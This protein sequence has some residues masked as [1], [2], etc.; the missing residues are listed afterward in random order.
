MTD[1][2]KNEFLTKVMQHMD[3]CLNAEEIMELESEM[4]E[5]E[6]KRVLFSE[7][8]LQSASLQDHMANASTTETRA[9][10]PFIFSPWLRTAA[11]LIVGV[12]IGV[13]SMTVANAFSKNQALLPSLGKLFESFEEG[14]EPEA[15]GI[16][17]QTL[18]WGGDSSK[19]TLTDQ[20]ITP[21]DG[22][23]MLRFLKADYPGKPIPGGYL[24]EIYRWVDLNEFNFK[25]DSEELDI[26]VSALFNATK[27]QSMEGLSCSLGVFAYESIPP[28]LAPTYNVEDLAK[29]SFAL[30]DRKIKSIDSNPKSWEN[31]KVNMPV[32]LKANFILIRISAY[33]HD[34]KQ[35]SP[36]LVFPGA[37][38]DDIKISF[39]KTAPGTP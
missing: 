34:T 17:Q 32:P 9:K 1:N 37:Y 26:V 27:E 31:I 30:T 38:V 11:V 15:K 29:T 36:E 39:I 23:K 13:S 16:P 28:E 2:E 12:I 22:Q 10:T 7:T 5:S 18:F 35:I 24:S 21:A 33:R 3:G 4:K 6:E 8:Y 20:Q 19:V 25:H 14:P